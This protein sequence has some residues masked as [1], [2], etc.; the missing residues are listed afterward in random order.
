MDSVLF[1]GLLILVFVGIPIGLGF[2]LFYIPKRLGYPKIAKY[3]IIGYG[4]IIVTILFFIIFE[5]QMFTK[6]QAKR[7]VEE[8]EIELLDEF[9]LINNES[10][11]AIGDYYH[12]FTLSISAIDR[13]NAISKIKNS[14]KIVKENESI[15][16][17]LYQQN[18]RYFGPKVIQNYETDKSYVR[19]YYEPS[20]R[21]GYAPTF[22]RISIS[23]TKNELF[24]EELIE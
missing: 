15:E 16:G 10:M 23:K 22:R 17:M 2:L 12:T 21:E 9:D 18:S 4:L 3:L 8:Q 7:L 6:N 11:S 13:Q 14:D 24:F 20:G 1:I 5:D 19:E